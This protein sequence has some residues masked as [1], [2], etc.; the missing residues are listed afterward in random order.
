MMFLKW[1]GWE[2]KIYYIYKE[3][4]KAPKNKYYYCTL[5]HLIFLYSLYLLPWI[6][7][8]SSFRYLPFSLCFDLLNRDFIFHNNE[9][10]LLIF[11]FLVPS[12]FWISFHVIKLKL[13]YFN[14]YHAKKILLIYHMI[15]NQAF[16]FSY[17]ISQMPCTPYPI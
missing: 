17:P 3:Y 12:K 6:V 2:K 4:Y 1:L 11:I 8:L 10:S 5:K 15:Q 9:I 13:I 16:K 7:S 14:T